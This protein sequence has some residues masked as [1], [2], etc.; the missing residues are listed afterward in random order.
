MAQTSHLAL[1]RGINVG[2]KNKLPM[3]ELAGLFLAAGATDVRTYIASG[4]VLFH[5]PATLARRLPALIAKEIAAQHSLEVPVVVRTVK[6]LETV[7][8]GN[9]FLRKDED[10]KPLAVL[11]LADEPAASAV[12]KLDPRRSVP[13][14][15]AVVGREVFLKLPNG[16]ADTRLTNDYF[17]RTL[18]TVSTARNWN[19]VLKLLALARG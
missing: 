2:G 11:F 12:K 14:E 7:T 17:D 18:D 16:F 6:E 15:F 10:T 9:P 13:D 5:A 8:V 19:T 3:K 1:L 4:N